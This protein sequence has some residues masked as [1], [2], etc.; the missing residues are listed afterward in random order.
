M[1]TSTAPAHRTY[2]RAPA[3]PIRPPDRR[4]TAGRHTYQL[5]KGCWL[6]LEDHHRGL[7]R[8]ERRKGVQLRVYL[9]PS[10]PQARPFVSLGHASP[11]RA[12]P[13]EENDAR[14]GMRLEVQPPGRFA[15]GP[16]VHRHRDEVRPI[17]KIGDD[18]AALAARA[19]PVVVRRR[20]PQR[21]PLGRQSP[22]RP[23]VTRY[24]PRCT[25]HARRTNQRGGSRGPRSAL[26]DMARPFPPSTDRFRAGL[27]P[28]SDR[29]W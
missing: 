14:V 28:R 19:S 9:A 8:P 11:H 10:A 20:V 27:V 4:Q 29:P 5:G 6:W 26:F 18:H 13:V 16:A 2:C 7:G 17:L 25:D 12:W 15:I 1:P 3:A 23:P 24:R 22:T 21:F